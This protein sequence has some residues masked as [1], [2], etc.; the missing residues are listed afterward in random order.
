MR[1]KQDPYQRGISTEVNHLRKKCQVRDS[2]C[3]L[4][5][6]Q[7]QRL[8]SRKAIDQISSKCWIK[9]GELR[10]IG[11][12]HQVKIAASRVSQ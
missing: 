11:L 3:I 12:P 6:H 5:T 2:R 8:V 10:R 7:V 1:T 9:L 4:G